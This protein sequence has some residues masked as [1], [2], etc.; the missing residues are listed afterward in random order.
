MLLLLFIHNYCM[1]NI[2]VLC[3]VYYV[4]LLLLK[5]MELWKK[6]CAKKEG[7]VQSDSETEK[8][9]AES[10]EVPEDDS[11]H[12]SHPRYEIRLTRKFEPT[13]LCEIFLTNWGKIAYII[14]LTIYCFL[15]CWSFT[16]VAGSAWATNIPFN[17]S[18]LQRCDSSEFLHVLIP[19]REPCR[20][21]YML[22]VFFFA[23]I[24]VSLSLL[25]LKEQAIL[26]MI[27]GLLRF[28]AIGGILLYVIVK[29]GEGNDECAFTF[30]ET[31]FTSIQ[32]TTE[33]YLPA[34]SSNI[35]WWWESTG[36]GLK[37]LSRIV[38]RFDSAGWLVSIPVFTYAFIIHQGIPALTHPIREKYLLR[39]FMVAMFGIAALSYISLGVV[40]PLWFKADIQETCT[41]NWVDYPLPYTQSVLRYSSIL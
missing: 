34:G 38:F 6:W 28:V 33:S 39:E 1:Y 24:T 10:T 40:V 3:T 7:Q 41:L 21:A 35:S 37:D 16:T 32:N 15:A 23:V 14:V 20:N 5:A 12:S 11:E 8:L 26:Q 18:S 27:L 17:S 4:Y 19:T 25:D 2:H 29:L 22:S 30:N 31:N 9:I 36:Y 13:E